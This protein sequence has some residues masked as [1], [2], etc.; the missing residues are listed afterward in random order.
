METAVAPLAS[1]FELNTD[2]LLNCLAGLSETEAQARLPGGGN[3]LAFLAAHLTDTR[4][5]LVERLG[6]PLANPLAG[7]L[8]DARGI[9]DIRSWPSLA[10]IRSAWIAV[11]SHVGHVL[12]SMSHEEVTQGIA[13]RLSLD[14]TRLGLIAFLAQHDA[15]HVGQMAFVRRQLGKPAMSYAR[16]ARTGSP[17]GQR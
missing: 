8:A 10:E 9:D 13:H 1:I 4:H 12:A 6:S 2:L 11:S 7:Y 15:Y 16:G 5:V 14:G 17:A 3:S